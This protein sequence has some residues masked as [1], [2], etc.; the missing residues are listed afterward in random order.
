MMWTQKLVPLRGKILEGG[1]EISLPRGEVAI[2][3]QMNCLCL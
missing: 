3:I 1:H 2:I